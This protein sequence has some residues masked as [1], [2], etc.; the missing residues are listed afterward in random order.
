MIGFKFWKK[1]LLLQGQKEN[2][3]YKSCLNLVILSP[4]IVIKIT[5]GLPFQGRMITRV[6]LV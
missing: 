4:I 3:G 1:F 2:A 5:I 6:L